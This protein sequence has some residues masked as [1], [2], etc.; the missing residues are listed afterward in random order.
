MIVPTVGDL[1]AALGA[2]NFVGKAHH[3]LFGLQLKL[4]E[5]GIA[6]FHLDQAAATGIAV[7]YGYRD[8]ATA[9]LDEGHNSDAIRLIGKE[10]QINQPWLGQFR[11]WLHNM[12][13]HS[14]E[15]W[16]W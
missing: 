1:V 16:V 2:D 3:V 7:L 14:D 11:S 15:N 9:Y 4:G 10:L 8:L 5:L 12:T 13:H 6:E